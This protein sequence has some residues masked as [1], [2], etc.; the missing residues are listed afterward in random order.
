[1]QVEEQEQTVR[2]G[3]ETVRKR[4]K[5]GQTDGNYVQYLDSHCSLCEW[6]GGPLEGTIEVERAANHS[7][8][9]KRLRRNKKART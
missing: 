6:G 3:S 8:G 1:M 2:K 7:E 5:E 9:M 4:R